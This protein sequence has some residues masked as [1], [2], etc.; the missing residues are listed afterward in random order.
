MKRSISTL[1]LCLLF[2]LLCACGFHLQGEKP[3]ALPLHRMYLQS[4]DPYG[5]LTHNLQ[6]SLKMSHVQLVNSPAEAETILVILQDSTSQTLLAPNGTLQTRQYILTVTVRFE[7]TDAKGR[8]LVPPQ[9]LVEQRPITIQS[10]QI[11]GSSSEVAM[12]Y[13]QMR[14]VLTYAIMNRLASQEVTRMIR[15]AYHSNLMQTH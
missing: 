8:I 12:Y 11:L 6:Q 10:N 14:R 7:I 5:H 1:F 15:D 13:Q 9:M 4:L 2:S 3:L